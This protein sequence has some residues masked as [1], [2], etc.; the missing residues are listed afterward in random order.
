MNQYFFEGFEKKARLYIPRI[1][2]LVATKRVARPQPIPKTEN[3]LDYAKMHAADRAKRA[4]KLV[5]EKERVLDYRK[6]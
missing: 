1:K 3:V 5:P 2:T 6:L 4:K